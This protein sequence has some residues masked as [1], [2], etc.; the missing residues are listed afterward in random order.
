VWLVLYPLR[1]PAHSGM[2]SER[3]HG[4]VASFE[5]RVSDGDVDVAVAGAAQGDRPTR[6]ASVELLS[7]LPPAFHLPGAGAGQEVVAGET[8]LPDA[9]AAQLAP[10]VRFE[11]VFAYHH[12]EIIRALQKERPRK[13]CYPLSGA[14][15]PA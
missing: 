9:P 5:V 11:V 1:E 8:T 3:L 6:V 13:K 7:A 2:V 15:P 12:P 4:V 10:A 14:G